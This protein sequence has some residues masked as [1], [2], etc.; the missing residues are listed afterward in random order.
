MWILIR[1]QKGRITK[2]V[3]C[4]LFDFIEGETWFQGSFIV[5]KCRIIFRLLFLH[6]T[7]NSL[8]FFLK[9]RH[10]L[11]FKG[12]IHQRICS[13][14]SVTI[15]AE[16]GLGLGRFPFKLRVENGL[17]IVWLKPPLLLTLVRVWQV[18]IGGYLHTI[19]TYDHKGRALENL[20][21][22][23]R[24][25]LTNYFMLVFY[26]TSILS[27]EELHGWSCDTGAI[28]KCFC[29]HI[30]GFFLQFPR[31]FIQFAKFSFYICVYCDS[32]Y[33]CE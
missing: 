9:R 23:F 12:S 24:R 19:F 3:C 5:P 7:L 4:I 10:H 33:I 17:A 29:L 20:L 11:F 21:E 16:L 15:R 1:C 13:E 32:K 25:T 18:L 14:K 28:Q 27:I 26:V 22:F 8:H 6:L 2:I 30:C 31:E